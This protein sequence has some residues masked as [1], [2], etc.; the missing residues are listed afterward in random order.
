MV[1]SNLLC[2]L[3]WKTSE[4]IIFSNPTHQEFDY[5]LIEQQTSRFG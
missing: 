1:V 3:K 4:L 2:I 5:D